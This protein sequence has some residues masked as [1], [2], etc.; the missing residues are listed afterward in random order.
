MESAYSYFDQLILAEINKCLHLVRT[1]NQNT[2]D[3]AVHETRKSLKKIRGW[4]KAVWSLPNARSFNRRLSTAGK[5]ISTLRDS[6][7]ALE[8]LEKIRLK[9]DPYLKPS[10]LDPLNEYLLNKKDTVA[11][12]AE[13]RLH[14]TEARLLEF[15]KS[16]EPFYINDP[17]DLLKGI[18][19]TYSAARSALLAIEEKIESEHL[20]EWRKRSKDLQYQ[21][22]LFPEKIVFMQSLNAEIALITTILGNDQDLY[23]LDNALRN[24][25]LDTL[26]V[27]LLEGIL[28]REHAQC[29]SEALTMGHKIFRDSKNIFI[30]TIAENIDDNLA[31]PNA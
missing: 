29:H 12:T 8:A 28:T 26:Q 19:R 10:T 4:L 21:C 6:S 16:Y 15:Q 20:H 18:S 5:E 7:S 9:Y 31:E 13:K 27:E 22:L 23:L 24:I 3:E 1:S 25:P 14:R 11:K 17:A 2:L 30:K